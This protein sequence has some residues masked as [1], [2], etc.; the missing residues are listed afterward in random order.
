MVK[1]HC[2]PNARLIEE[3]VGVGS[4]RRN[5]VFIV[6]LEGIKAGTEVKIDYSDDTSDVKIKPNGRRPI[7]IGDCNSA[8]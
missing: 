5:V 7:V 1:H 8:V 2:E 3:G 4:G 6:A